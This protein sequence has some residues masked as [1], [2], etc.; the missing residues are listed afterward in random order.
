MRAA[1]TRKPAP[2]NRR[3][4][5]PIKLRPTPSGFTM[6]R[7][8]SIAILTSGALYGKSAPKGADKDRE[9]YWRGALQAIRTGAE[10]PVLL[11][12]TGPWL[13]GSDG[14]QRLNQTLKLSPQPHS[15]LAL[16]F[17]N[18]NASFRPCLTKSTSVPSINGRLVGSTT[19][20]KALRPI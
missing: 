15:P 8:R 5:S 4:T 16:G 12:K 19:P 9:V 20:F 13:Q 18:L 6:E 3:Y 1:I 14:A 17:W 10:V 11:G 2:S 7:V